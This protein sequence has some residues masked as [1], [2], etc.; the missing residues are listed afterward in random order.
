MPREFHNVWIAQCEAAEGIR[1]QWSSQKALGYVVGEK[2][3][4]F[5]R[6]AE[7]SPEWNE[8]VPLFMAELKRIFSPEE[9]RAYLDGV[10]RIGPLG[11]VMSDEQF[12]EFRAAGAVEDNP[13]LGAE[14]VLRL[15][16][17][18]RLLLGE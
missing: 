7:Q 2:L 10:R 6:V 14:D 3:V 1:D 15:H 17:A 4:E 13:V 11:H 9:I 16:R 5:L 18:R 12:E 8:Q